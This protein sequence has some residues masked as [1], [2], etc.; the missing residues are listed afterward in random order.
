MGYNYLL[1]DDSFPDLLDVMV[2]SQDSLD[3]EGVQ[4]VLRRGEVGFRDSRRLLVVESL[5]DLVLLE[6]EFLHI[7]TTY[8]HRV[9]DLFAI[10]FERNA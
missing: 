10:L 2:S 3:H 1:L 7:Y 4:L 9:N 6:A 5:Y 8:S